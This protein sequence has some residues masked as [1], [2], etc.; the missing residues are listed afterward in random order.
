MGTV[1]ELARLHRTALEHL[2]LDGRPVLIGGARTSRSGCR[3]RHATSTS[4]CSEWVDDGRRRDR[5]TVPELV[6]DAS[7]SGRPTGHPVAPFSAARRTGRPGRRP[8]LVGRARRR[9]APDGMDHPR[10]R[11]PAADRRRSARPADRSTPNACRR[12]D[13]AQSSYDAR[14]DRTTRLG[15][16]PRRQ[17]A[18]GA[19]EGRHVGHRSRTREWFATQEDALAATCP[20]GTTGTPRQQHPD[21]H[22]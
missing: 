9:R 18:R 20:E 19:D 3:S 17:C 4:R 11:R 15:D 2:G 7:G 14:R 12:S 1:V 6:A 21:A 22:D 8:A 16:P 5:A 13:R 10:R